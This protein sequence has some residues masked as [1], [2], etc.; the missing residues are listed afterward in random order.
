V[1]VIVAPEGQVAIAQYIDRTFGW[2]E[3]AESEHS[4]IRFF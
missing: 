1:L 4:V 2:Q 3:L